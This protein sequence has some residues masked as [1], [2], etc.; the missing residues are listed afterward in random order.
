MQKSWMML[1]G[2]VVAFGVACGE[3]ADPE[4]TSSKTGKPLDEEQSVPVESAAK[5]VLN[6]DFG[7]V[8]V[9]GQAGATQVDM[10]PT[11][12]SS[13]P[14]AGNI[15]VYVDGDTMIVQVNNTSGGDVRVDV[16]VT[17]PE[18]LSFDVNTG[19]GTLNLTGMKGSGKAN[20]Q[21]GNCTVDMD[22]GTDGSLQLNTNAGNISV[23]VPAATAGTL[24][25][26]AT[27]GGGSVSISSNLNFDGANVAGSATGNLNG[28]GSV[29]LTLNTMSGSISVT[30]R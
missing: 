26:S 14:E 17:T 12:H 2:V 19:G 8:V 4:T 18:N 30:G 7:N 6:N 9:R 5:L 29:E 3:T 1:A 20:T 22:P 21:D 16:E 13:D 10:R 15:E 28:G 23:T 24:T 25:A 27:S 11:L